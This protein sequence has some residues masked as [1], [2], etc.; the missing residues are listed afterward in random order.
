MDAKSIEAALMKSAELVERYGDRYLPAFVRLEEEL[1][2]EQAKS[3]ALARVRGRLPGSHM[4]HK[5]VT[6][7][8][9]TD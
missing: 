7:P 2:K 1:A 8:A 3:D 4:G 5:W 9:A 6:Q